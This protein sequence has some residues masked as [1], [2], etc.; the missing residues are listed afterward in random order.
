MSAKKIKKNYDNA[1]HEANISK[2]VNK[3]LHQKV[4]NLTQ[5]H[6]MWQTVS[7]ENIKLQ[8]QLKELYIYKS[9][10]NDGTV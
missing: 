1:V 10:F 5:Y 3:K 9:H 2:Q 8:K 7:S 6:N 4:D